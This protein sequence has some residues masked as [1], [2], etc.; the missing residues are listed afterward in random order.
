MNWRYVTLGTVLAGAACFA[1]PVSAA[2][3]D[4][5]VLILA[6][7]LARADAIWMAQAQGFFKAGGLAVSVRWMTTGADMLGVFGQGRAGVMVFS[8]PNASRVKASVSGRGTS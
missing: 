8:G 4:Q 1:E 7:P 2:G 3:E 5:P 6:Q